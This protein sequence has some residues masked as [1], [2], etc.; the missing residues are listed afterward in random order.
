[1][2]HI[3]ADTLQKIQAT[4]EAQK[5][6]LLSVRL[7]VDAENPANDTSRLDNNASSDA[8]AA[9]EVM[10]VQTEVVG[11]QVD[12]SLTRVEAALNRIKDGTYGLDEYGQPIPVGR[13]LADPTAVSQ[14]K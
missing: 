7:G 1:M 2:N 13:L 11:T 9:E 6:K 8:D 14:V 12:E 3:P 4:L 5:K 10:L